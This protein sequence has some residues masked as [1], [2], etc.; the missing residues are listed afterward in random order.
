MPFVVRLGVKRNFLLQRNL[1]IVGGSALY[2]LYADL[3]GLGFWQDRTGFGHINKGCADRADCA[4][5]KIAGVAC[6]GVRGVLWHRRS[7]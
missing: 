5:L 2:A 7:H 1:A 3:C 6:V 4:D